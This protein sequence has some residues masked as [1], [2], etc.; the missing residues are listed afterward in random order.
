MTHSYPRLI[1]IEECIS[2]VF[3]LLWED[4]SLVTFGHHSLRSFEWV[5]ILYF[6]LERTEV[7]HFSFLDKIDR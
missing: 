3:Y 7:G 5:T 2:G 1:L 4:V 6:T